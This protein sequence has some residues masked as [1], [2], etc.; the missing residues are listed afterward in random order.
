[1]EFG[2]CVET[3]MGHIVQMKDQEQFIEAL[4]VLNELPGLWHARG[5]P[6]APT[7]LVTDTHYR[8]LVKAGVVSS[9]GKEDKSRGKKATARKAKS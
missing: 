3:K 6:A 4:G 2:P 7:L 1:M 8:A 5:N 9:N